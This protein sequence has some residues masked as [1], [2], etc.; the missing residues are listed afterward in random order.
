MKDTWT[1][2]MNAILYIFHPYQKIELFFS[3]IFN[4]FNGIFFFII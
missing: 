3:S 4:I 1:A 2:P